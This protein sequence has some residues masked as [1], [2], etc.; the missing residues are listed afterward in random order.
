M[1]HRIFIGSS[2]Q[3][4]PVAHNVQLNLFKWSD[5][6]VWDQGIFQLSAGNLENLLSVLDI[7][8][9]GV[10]VF[11]PSDILVTEGGTTAA[12]RDNVLFELGLFIGRLGRERS[13]IVRPRGVSMRWPS[14]L[15]G[16]LS[17]E[18]NPTASNPE[19][20]VAEACIRIQRAVESY[21]P[22]PTSLLQ[23]HFAETMARIDR[24]YDPEVE[25]LLS[26]TNQRLLSS[27]VIRRNWTIHL[28]Y[29]FSSIDQH[30]IREAI[31]WDY[32]FINITTK[33]ITYQ[34]K[35]LSLD[36]MEDNELISFIRIDP[37]SGTQTPVFTPSSFRA[38][39]TG[40]I[41]RTETDIILE[42]SIPHF[43]KMKFLFNHPVSP[44]RHFIHNSFAPLEATMHAKIV[45][46]IP[47]GYQM[48]VLVL[49]HPLQPDRLHGT[50]EFRIPG[51]LLPEQII[52][53]VFE[54]V[55]S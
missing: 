45:A 32:E 9:F 13:F 18:Y 12:V 40:M 41:K 49:D 5:P 10:F 39:T 43:I 3:S 35:F 4:L 44:I 7:F 6:E 50:C 36:N 29:D 55:R 37:K 33:Q 19:A 38:E 1:A 34:K 22:T 11:T 15:E 14:D 53:Y 21:R 48:S 28:S 8:D 52:E 24:R 31:L 20:A 16:I 17:A 2:T 54:K 46:D 51:P 25:F 26:T 23:K 27:G 30:I 42:P 47:D